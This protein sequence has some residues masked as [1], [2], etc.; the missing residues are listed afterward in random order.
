MK[1]DSSATSE[2]GGFA[3]D[4][5]ACIAIAT[6]VVHADAHV[7]DHDVALKVVTT[8]VA[9]NG[10]EEHD[11]THGAVNRLNVDEVFND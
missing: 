6:R 5:T 11:L 7:V 3:I 10:L 8:A 9:I 1:F 2:C 4:A